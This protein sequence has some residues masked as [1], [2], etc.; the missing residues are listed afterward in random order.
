MRR[1][2]YSEPGRHALAAKGVRTA[3]P[4]HTPYRV[5]KAMILSYKEMRKIK[6]IELEIEVLERQIEKNKD[7]LQ[8]LDE[9]FIEAEASGDT[10]LAKRVLLLQRE[11]MID[12]ERHIDKL[13][14]DVN[15]V[16]RKHGNERVFVKVS[17]DIAEL[18]LDYN[19]LVMK[20]G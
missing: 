12:L 17:N 2:W 8:R 14:D 13:H 10:S 7:M 4:S 5:Q 16:Q 20:Y 18:A 15:I 11:M 19:A 9:V 6:Q 3:K 1:G